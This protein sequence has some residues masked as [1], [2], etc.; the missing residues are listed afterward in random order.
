MR[1]PACGA[2]N[3]TQLR[4]EVEAARLPNEPRGEKFTA[5][6]E[7]LAWFGCKCHHLRQGV[8]HIRRADG[9]EEVR[10]RW[11][12]VANLTGALDSLYVEENNLDS[13]II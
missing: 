12:I 3:L 13:Q 2:G 6:P 7:A 4:L 10:R 11:V 1:C 5:T 9:E 8:L